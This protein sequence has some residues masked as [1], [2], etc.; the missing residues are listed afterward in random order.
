MMKVPFRRAMFAIGAA[1]ACIVTPGVV[2][3]MTGLEMPEAMRA[4]SAR[5]GPQIYRI[6]PG[7][8]RFVIDVEKAGVFSFAAGHTHE[9]ETHAIDGMVRAALD[10]LPHSSVRVQVDAASLR[11]TGKGEPP[12]DVPQVQQAMLSEK[13]LDVAHYTTIRFESAHVSRQKGGD[14]TTLVVSGRLTLHGVTKTVVVPV[15]VRIEGRTLTAT[16]Q[17]PIKQTDYGITPISVAGLVKV[18]DELGV[19]FTIVA[20]TDAGGS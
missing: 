9:V 13:V 6:D 3:A 17:I 12:G 15:K 5:I 18:K 1:V 11:V 14:A 10:D 2:R 8:S 16:G 19:S 20:A 4:G 7:R